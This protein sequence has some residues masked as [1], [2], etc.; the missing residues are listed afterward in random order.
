MERAI[1][2]GRGAA[3]VVEH[4]RRKEHV[5]PDE[6]LLRAVARMQRLGARQLAVVERGTGKLAGIL[7]M[8]DVLRAQ[9]R[10][11]EP[12]E[13]ASRESIDTLSPSP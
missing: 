5:H 13:R 4:A 7:A 10:A 1:A 9:V 2:E 12:D 8:S 6:T 11:S 3:P